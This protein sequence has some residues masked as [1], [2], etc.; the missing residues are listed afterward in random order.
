MDRA[1]RPRRA[2]AIALATLLVPLVVGPVSAAKTPKVDVCHLDQVLGTYSVTTIAV[3]SL[4][5][6]LA[7]G[8]GLPGDGTFDE[9][10][11]P[12]SPARVF[13]RAF[14]D[15]NGNHT[16][17]RDADVLFTEL[18]DTNGS[19][20]LDVGDTVR[21]IEYPVDFIGGS[22]PYGVEDHVVTD[23]PAGQGPTAVGVSVD[24]PAGFT[25]YTWIRV[26]IGEAFQEATIT[27]IDIT[28][29]FQDL[30]VS[31]ADKI[32]MS[33]LSPSHPADLD[34]E[35]PFDGDDGWLEIAIY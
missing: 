7:H 18:V 3:S 21:T 27:G 11:Q 19:D 5:K 16:Y 8:D 15:K 28:S 2:L 13:A 31:D 34:I 32:Q 12:V 24:D 29:R 4:A 33:S 6:H 20:V 10:C 1:R 25:S 35:K 14:A 23:V 26:E 30:F 22:E 17:D 9:N